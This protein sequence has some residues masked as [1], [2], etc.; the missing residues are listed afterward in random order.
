M[1]DVLLITK[2]MK[3]SKKLINNISSKNIRVIAIASTFKEIKYSL[4]SY[5]ADIIVIDLKYSDYI[6]V[7]N[8]KLI[9]E[10]RYK[11]SVILIKESI[12][13]NEIECF[14]ESPYLYKEIEKSNDISDVVNIIKQLA[15]LKENNLINNMENDIEKIIREKIKHE[16]EYLGY[17]FSHNGTK[18]IIEAIYVLA[19]IKT[20]GEDNLEKD[21]YPLVGNKFDKST[22]NIKC[23]IRNA[24]ENMIAECEEEKLRNYLYD[25]KFIKPG[26]KRIIFTV[27][28]KLRLK[29]REN[30]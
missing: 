18:Y 12:I 20:Y 16:L 4:N 9:S 30:I 6:K 28:G 22:H 15:T 8:S 3:Y 10:C 11:K 13:E 26:P 23:N 19:T 1:I 29:R 27:L 21:I 7:K 2:D 14:V 17:N 5:N 24:T 25:Y